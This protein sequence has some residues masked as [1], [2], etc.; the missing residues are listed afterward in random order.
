MKVLIIDDSQDFCL[1]L[2][3]VLEKNDCQVAC[4]QESKNISEKISNFSPDVILL[5]VVMPNKS[6]IDVLAEIKKLN[7]SI[8]VIMISN[9]EDAKLIVGAM[10]AGASDY[11]PKTIDSQELVKKIQSVYNIGMMKETGD[12]LKTY[13]DIIGVSNS[14]KNLINMISTVSQSDAPVFLRG[15]SGTGKSMVAETIHKYSKRRNGPF[16]TINCPAIPSTLLETEFFGHEKGSFTGAIKN[17]EGK[18]EIATGGT[19]FLDEIGDLTIDLQVK[20]LRIIQ[21]KEFERVGGLKTLKTDVRIIAATN[22]NVEQAVK[23]GKFREDL[24]Y[25]LNVLPIYIPSLKERKDDVPILAEHFLKLSSKREGKNFN[26]LSQEV[27]NLLTA[28]D[29]PGNIRELENSIERA[30]ILGKEPDIKA[31]DFS[32]TKNIKTNTDPNSIF[33]SEPQFTSLR[34]MEYSDLVSA[35]KRS[36]GNISQTAKTLGISRDTLYRR[37]RK[38]GIGLKN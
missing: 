11:I 35:L 3:K 29:W 31:E 17:K 23:D 6:G 15:D 24:Y 21:N 5:D 8:P 33:S 9:R 25:R 1:V 10:K 27:I 38:H 7:A 26:K 20:I 18:F 30:I 34:D 4:Y 36:S 37:M 2:S 32:F 22:Q 12:G 16:V 28:Y 13:A 19:V 14:T